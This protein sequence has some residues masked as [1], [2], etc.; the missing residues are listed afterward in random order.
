VNEFL[1]NHYSIDPTSKPLLN[2]VMGSF[3]GVQLFIVKTKLASAGRQLL[4]HIHFDM[5]LDMTPA[6]GAAVI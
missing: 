2:A 3:I 5:L 4:E 6:L 1:V